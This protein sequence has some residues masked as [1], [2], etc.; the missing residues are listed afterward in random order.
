MKILSSVIHP[1]VIPNLC[2]F[3]KRRYFGKCLSLFQCFIKSAFHF[4]TCSRAAWF[5]LLNKSIKLP[6]I[7][8]SKEIKLA[9]D[10]NLK[11]WHERSLTNWRCM[12][13]ATPDHLTPILEVA[14]GCVD[15]KETD[16]A[17]PWQL[18]IHAWL[19][20]Y[21]NQYQN[22]AKEKFVSPKEQIS[23][24]Y[25]TY[26]PIQHCFAFRHGLDHKGHSLLEY[27]S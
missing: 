20:K 10:H 22:N 7:W 1:Q 14:K 15:L 5:C 18:A 21:T 9:F 23:L 6:L 17:K 11:C 12:L 8:M 19:A 3:D 16:L 25:Q 27:K 2:D 13:E 4:N 26:Q 24:G